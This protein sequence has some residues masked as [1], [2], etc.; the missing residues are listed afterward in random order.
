MVDSIMKK[1]KA[2]KAIQ[3][4]LMHALAL[5]TQVTSRCS[6]QRDDLS[7]QARQRFVDIVVLH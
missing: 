4:G 2:Q 3:Q 5:Y 7:S 1:N 6:V